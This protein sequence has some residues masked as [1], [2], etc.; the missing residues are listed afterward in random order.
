MI[1]HSHRRSLVLLPARTENPENEI[2]NEFLAVDTETPFLTCLYRAIIENECTGYEGND[3]GANLWLDYVG[4][5]GLFFSIH[6]N[7]Q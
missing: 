5:A 6:D 4:P 7:E 1:R 2:P 3:M